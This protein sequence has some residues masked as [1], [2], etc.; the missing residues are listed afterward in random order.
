MKERNYTLSAEDYAALADEIR[1]RLTTPC[2]FTG[3][4]E[5]RGSEGESLR[6]TA[7]LIL[8]RRQVDDP[9]AYGAHDSIY[10][11][12][13]VWWDFVCE[14]E[15]GH[16]FDDFDFAEFRQYLIEEE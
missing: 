1:G 13:P 15:D 7:S 4:V 10:A 14:D 8:Y 2:Y 3:A 11:V 6:F 9:T 16:L 5:T 12:A